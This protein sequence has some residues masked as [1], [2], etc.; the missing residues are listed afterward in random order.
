MTRGSLICPPRFGTARTSR[1]TLGDKAAVIAARLHRPLMPWQRYV[2]DVGLELNPDGSLVYSEVDLEVGRQEGK[3]ELKFVIAVMRLTVFV[4]THGPQRVTYTMQNRKK[5]RTRLERDYAARLRGGAGFKEIRP[6]SRER[7]RKAT[8]WRLGMNSGV[9]AI[10][11]GP[12]SWLQ[13]DTPSRTDGHGDTLDLGLIDEAFAHQDD[14]VELGMEPAMLTRTDPQLWVLSAGGDAKSVYLWRKILRGRKLVEDGCDS[15]VAFFEWS[16][17]DDADPADP[18][19]WRSC[20]PALGFTVTE[21]RLDSLW[22]K[23]AVEGPT[24]IDSFR[25]SYL[26]QWP[27]IPVL[28][29]EIAAWRH[30]SK[31]G[32]DD[33]AEFQH[34]PEG[35]IAH[36]IDADFDAKGELWVSIGASNGT[37]LEV[38]TPPAG[39]SRHWMG[40]PE[41][42]REPFPARRARDRPERSRRSV[43]RPARAGRVRRAQ[44]HGPRVRPSVRPTRRRRGRRPGLSP[45]PAPAEHRSV[46]R[47]TQRP[48]RRV[49]A[50]VAQS[51][52]RRH[53]PAERRHV[54]P[55]DGPRPHRQNTRLLR[56]G[57][58][59]NEL[60]DP[61]QGVRV[62]L[63]TV[64]EVAGFA[65]VAVAAGA[66][67]WRLLVALIGVA[68]IAVSYAIG[69]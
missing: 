56:I 5:A 36:S 29:D 14:T 41:V 35:P 27:E 67:D 33:C 22:R 47:R 52:A 8:E 12:E 44:G 39:R 32:W 17:A 42:C 40:G 59:M 20:C 57:G 15:G 24:A 21:D 68:L 62:D 13:I 50:L 6:T 60:Q 54:G 28:T 23:A 48:R 46:T 25:R 10:Q 18:A 55:V 51:I 34:T 43:D 9:E 63:S 69:R 7:P 16:A 2:A 64:L 1:P 66:F 61:Q 31:A 58:L 4:A 53:R 45:R 3:T 38:V 26:S 49:V 65:L 19:T 30:L 37:H 11:F